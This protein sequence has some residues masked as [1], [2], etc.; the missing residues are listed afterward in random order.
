M[1]IETKPG[2]ARRKSNL[3]PFSIMLIFFFTAVG[4][5]LYVNNAIVVNAL[6]TKQNTLKSDY[7]RHRAMNEKLQLEINKLS[8]LERIEKIAKDELQLQ[9][10]QQKPLSLTK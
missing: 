6:V 7:D 4:I 8:A 2:R 3:S 9:Y 5:I 1:Q 10:A